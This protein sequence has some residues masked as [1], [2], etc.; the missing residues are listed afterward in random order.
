M[1]KAN[2]DDEK[3]VVEL[4]IKGQSEA[5][6]QLFNRYRNEIF[7]YSCKISKRREFAEE[8]VQ[9]VFMIVWQKRE[10]LNPDL[11]IAPYLYTITQNISFNFLK[12]A[13]NETRLKK[14]VFY[15][16]QKDFRP[17][18]GTDHKDTLFLIGKAVTLL[19]A[20]Q[21]EIF[22]LSRDE[23]KSHDE[24]SDLLRISKNTVKDQIFKALKFI[25]LYLKG[26]KTPL[27]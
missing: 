17:E 23:M 20:R 24:I 2:I 4:L 12:K 5:F 14:E 19:P 8:I 18:W 10:G 6:R 16:S 22:L 11:P 15:R 21:R 1:P 3:Q 7:T 27:P 9:D 13:A 25:K 26:N